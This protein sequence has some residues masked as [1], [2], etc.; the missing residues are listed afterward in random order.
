MQLFLHSE[1][2]CSV[3][4][5]VD[6]TVIGDSHERYLSRNPLNG[7]FLNSKYD[8][9]TQHI[10]ALLVNTFQVHLYPSSGV[11]DCKKHLLVLHNKI[12]Q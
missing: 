6:F 4:I 8:N 10:V 5:P 1:N 11:Q 2:K 9:K 3:G 12:L 7:L